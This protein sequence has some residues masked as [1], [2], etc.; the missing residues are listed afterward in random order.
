MLASGNACAGSRAG[1]TSP[2]GIRLS[3]VKTTSKN[4][5]SVIPNPSLRSSD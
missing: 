3:N 1:I 4:Q 2:E 5:K